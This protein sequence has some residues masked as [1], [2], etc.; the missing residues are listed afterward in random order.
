MKLCLA[1]ILTR[2][3]VVSVANSTMGALVTLATWVFRLKTK[4][5][6]CF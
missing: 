3:M 6:T 4:S 2:R 1:T 5:L